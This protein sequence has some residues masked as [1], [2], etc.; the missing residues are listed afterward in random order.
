[1]T[2][3]KYSN[4]IVREDCFVMSVIDVG[5]ENWGKEVENTPNLV[6]IEFWSPNCIWCQKLEP[7]YQEL[8]EEYL[9]RIKFVKA[10]VVT[11]SQLATSFGVMGTP[12]IKFLCTG[13]SV[14]E[15]VGF[16]AKDLL[17]TKLDEVFKYHRT[18]LNQ[19]SPYG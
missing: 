16:A 9:G 3:L 7:I 19:S 17:K 11:E 15:H 13:R 8:A 1:M 12:T 18:C 14:G 4:H 10:N 2:Y 5:I 6:A